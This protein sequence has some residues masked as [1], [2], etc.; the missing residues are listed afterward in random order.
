MLVTGS[1]VLYKSNR[2]VLLK[3]IDSFLNSRHDYPCILFL[4]DNSPT[5]DLKELKTDERIVYIFNPSNPGFGAA[6]NIAIKK[7]IEMDSKYHFV[8]NPDVFFNT[9][10]ISSMV[11]YIMGDCKIGM[12]MPKILNTDLTRQNLPKLLP[13]PIDVVLR[14]LKKPDFIYK[15]FINKYELRFVEDNR[16]YQAPILSGCF[17]LFN[18]DALK[19]KGLY[20]DGF[21]MY[22]ED[23][24][25]SRRISQSYK[26]IVFQEVSVVHEYESGAN[27]NKKL[28]QIFLKSAFH[29]FNKWGW[30]F[31]RERKKINS[32]ILSQFK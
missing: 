19:T 8:I 1:I 14:K 18:V 5:D 30:F 7:A 20:D 22:F 25:I 6:H 3:A 32:E 29:Y 17:T 28:F 31:D 26:T 21:F 23:W 9:H 12:M 27:R 16:I 2:V 11:N 4:I 15:P 10:V 24:D 13:A